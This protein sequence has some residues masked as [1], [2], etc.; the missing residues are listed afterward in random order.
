MDL[1]IQLLLKNIHS[2]QLSCFYCASIALRRTIRNHHHHTQRYLRLRPG[3]SKV[4]HGKGK[5]KQVS[6]RPV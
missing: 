4:T 2:V 3:D 1:C 6:N 5:E